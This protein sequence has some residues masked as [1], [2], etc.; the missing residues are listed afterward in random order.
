MATFNGEKI[1]FVEKHFLVSTN[2]LGFIK[3]Y[4]EHQSAA[5]EKLL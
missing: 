3:L 1:V 4:I 5:F 2:R